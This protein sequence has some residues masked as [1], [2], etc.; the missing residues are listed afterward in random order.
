MVV[1][2]KVRIYFVY[3][4]FTT[5]NLLAAAPPPPSK[6]KVRLSKSKILSSTIALIIITTINELFHQVV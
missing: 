1:K 2:Y 3:T 6:A 5:S 4:Y